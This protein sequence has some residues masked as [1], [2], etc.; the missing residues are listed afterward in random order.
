MGIPRV[1]MKAYMAAACPERAGSTMACVAK[2]TADRVAPKPAPKIQS[3]GERAALGV[4][5]SNRIR[6]PEASAVMA[7]PP[8]TAQRYRPHRVMSKDTM[9]DPG[10]ERATAGSRPMPERRG[11]A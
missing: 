3:T 10:R 1:R 6:R 7:H 9:I 2:F 5:R 11:E 4:G 8:Q